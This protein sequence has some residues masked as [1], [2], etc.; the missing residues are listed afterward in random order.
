MMVVYTCAAVVAAIVAGL[1]LAIRTKKAEEIT[2]TKLDKAGRITNI[3]MLIAYICSAPVYLFLAMISSP[4][5]EGFLAVIGWIISIIIGSA[6]LFCG[7]GLGL[8]VAWRKQGKSKESF[9]VQ[10]A[11]VIG[12]ALSVGLYC[13]CAGNLIAP[14]N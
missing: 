3:V 6:P 13:L 1:I 11:G 7:I 14:L 10:F 8:S 4:G 12:I 5:E 2:Y 9:M